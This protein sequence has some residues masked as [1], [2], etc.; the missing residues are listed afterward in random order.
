[1]GYLEWN[2]DNF[3]KESIK[4]HCNFSNIL[5]LYIVSGL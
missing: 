2:F 4:N 1:M 5:L 3:L